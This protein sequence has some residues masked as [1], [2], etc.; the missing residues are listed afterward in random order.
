KKGPDY[1]Q[2]NEMTDSTRQAVIILATFF[3]ESRDGSTAGFFADSPEAARQ[4]W[5]TVKLLL[6]GDREV[7]L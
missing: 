2:T 3:Y 7:I 4:V 6:Q 1:Y 5:E